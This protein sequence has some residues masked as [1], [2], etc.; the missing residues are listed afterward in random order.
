[1]RIVILLWIVAAASLLGYNYAYAAENEQPVT[2]DWEAPVE[3]PPFTLIPAPSPPNT[4]TFTLP[5]GYQ[6]IVRIMPPN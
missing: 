5:P 2:I 3:I 1:M 6:A 4:V